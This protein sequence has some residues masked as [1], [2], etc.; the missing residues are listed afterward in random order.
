M[1]IFATAIGWLLVACA[2][3]GVCYAVASARSVEHFF[4]TPSAPERDRP[5]VTV[6][7]P[8]HGAERG[9]LENLE[10]FCA[11]DYPSAVQILFGLQDAKDSAIAI[12]KTLQERH[13]QLDLVLVTGTYREAPNPKIANLITMLPH[14]KHDILVLSDSDIGVGPLY[15]RTSSARSASPESAR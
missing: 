9:L 14:A 12:V 8:L 11:Q 1:L 13:P 7:K 4:R 15:L 5:P 6:L 3:I 10:S 2:L